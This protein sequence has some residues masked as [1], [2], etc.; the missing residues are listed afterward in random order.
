VGQAVKIV[1]YT[2]GHYEVQDVEFGTV[3]KWLPK[4]ILL[5]CECGEMTTL[6][7]SKTTC[8]ECGAEHAG[9]VREDLANHQLGDEDLHPWRS[10]EIHTAAA[11]LPY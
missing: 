11:G 7:V 5:E 8:E 3:Y 1:D 9:L 2:A 10:S 4:S 6:I